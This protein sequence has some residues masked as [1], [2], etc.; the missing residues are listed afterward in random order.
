MAEHSS[1]GR[2]QDRKRVAGGQ[3]HEVRYEADKKDVSKQDVKGAIE[4]AGTAVA[5]RRR[6][7]QVLMLTVALSAKLRWQIGPPHAD[8]IAERLY[9]PFAEPGG[10]G[11]T[12]IKS[13]KELAG[14]D[15]LVMASDFAR[16]GA[17]ALDHSPDPA[18]QDAV[19]AM[20]GEEDSTMVMLRWQP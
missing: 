1:R 14:H 13:A 2:C 15:V 16:E 4:D 7:R 19:I 12:E 9:Q 5:S 10:F 6:T 18:L 3:N 17:R 8:R 20:A 11:G